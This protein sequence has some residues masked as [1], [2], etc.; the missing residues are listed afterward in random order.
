MREKGRRRERERG[1]QNEDE[2]MTTGN[3]QV[4]VSTT[5]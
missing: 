5:V 3:V 2:K 4:E 1:K